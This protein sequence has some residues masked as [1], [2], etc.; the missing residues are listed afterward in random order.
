MKQQKKSKTKD[1]LSI[2]PFNF[3]L[4]K[5]V[6]PLKSRLLHWDKR[7]EK[8]PAR[9][10]FQPVGVTSLSKLTDSLF[11]E[12]ARIWDRKGKNARNTKQKIRTCKCMYKRKLLN[13]RRT[14][15]H[16]EETLAFRNRDWPQVFCIAGGFFTIWAS[17]GATWCNV[18]S[19]LSLRLIAKHSLFQ[20]CTCLFNS[21]TVSCSYCHSSHLWIHS[22]THPARG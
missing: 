21:K 7:N 5:D 18:K 4:G 9:P 22:S 20:P 19:H 2:H 15:C 6:S 13:S 10:D 8:Q 12:G 1:L 11:K 16:R 3:D 17:R 14:V